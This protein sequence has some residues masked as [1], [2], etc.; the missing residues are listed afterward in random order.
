MGREA[1]AVPAPFR[2]DRSWSFDTGRWELWE[3][4]ERTDRYPAWWSWLR[5]FE[6]P[7]GFTAGTQWRCLVAPPL[8]YV[9]RFTIHL[10]EVLPGELVVAHVSG[11]IA[12]T[13]RLELEERSPSDSVARLRSSL[14]PS[15]RV[16]RSFGRVA[17]PLVE[18]GHDWVLD[19]GRRQFCERAL[20]GA[21]PP[22]R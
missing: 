16:L 2:S 19:Q 5:S 20:P 7:D 6:A 22:P 8:P 9:L 21:S 11:D 4:I 13:A 3:A 17:R 1:V 15:N 12:G 10:D 14:A 18:W